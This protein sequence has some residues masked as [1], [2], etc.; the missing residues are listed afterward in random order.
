MLC[1]HNICFGWKVRFFFTHSYLPVWIH[2]LWTGIGIWKFLSVSCEYFLIHQFKHVFWV[3]A[4]KIVSLRSWHPL[5][6]TALLST[7]NICL[8]WEIRKIIF[9]CTILTGGL[10]TSLMDRLKYFME[11]ISSLMF[12]FSLGSY[13]PQLML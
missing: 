10:K 2:L 12:I 9:H 4:Q 3:A 6:E 13:C 8:D 7:H 11:V 1:T 5:I